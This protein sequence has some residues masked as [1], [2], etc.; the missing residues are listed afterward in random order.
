MATLADSRPEH[1]G[2]IDP[3]QAPEFAELSF[4][5][6]EMDDIEWDAAI[7]SYDRLSDI[8]LVFV[9]DRSQPA[10]VVYGKD[11]DDHRSYLVNP[12]T[13]QFVGWQIESFLTSLVSREPS[14]INAL[15]G[16]ELIGISNHELHDERE[17]ALAHGGRHRSRLSQAVADVQQRRSSS[18]AEA[19]R[20]LI[21]SKRP[22]LAHSP[23]FGA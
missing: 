13:R 9:G 1:I 2:P 15:D 6:P 18:K 7:V 20:G 16:A 11:A 14:L 22:P 23:S 21:A 3:D 17:L 10:V 12:D 19:L 4:T 5:M 8:L